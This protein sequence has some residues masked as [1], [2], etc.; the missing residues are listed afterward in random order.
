MKTNCVDEPIIKSY[1]DS[2]LYFH[3]RHQITCRAR[4][5][6]GWVCK[7]SLCRSQ[8]GRAF[9][10]FLQEGGW[11]KRSEGWVE[12]WWWWGGGGRGGGGFSEA[13]GQAGTQWL[14]RQKPFTVG[15]RDTYRT[16]ARIQCPLANNVPGQ[17]SAQCKP[18]KNVINRK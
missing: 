11:E 8:I 9:C 16:Y 5:V 6:C 4:F 3:K 1:Y 10:S 15:H 14:S 13:R 12:W 2:Y 7:S 18:Y 17:L